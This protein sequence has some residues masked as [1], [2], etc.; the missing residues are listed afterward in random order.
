MTWEKEAN[1]QH[2]RYMMIFKNESSIEDAYTVKE[3][4]ELLRDL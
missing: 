4:I 2:Y 1:K 3:A